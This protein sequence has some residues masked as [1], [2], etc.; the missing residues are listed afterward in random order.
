M[1][2]NRN[3]VDIH[4]NSINSIYHPLSLDQRHRII[5]LHTTQ[6]LGATAIYNR[7]IA[8]GEEVSRTSIQRCIT[9]YEREERIEALPKGGY[10][11]RTP[12]ELEDELCAFGSC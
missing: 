7:F 1:Q 4:V 3:D 10:Q 5:K 12:F 2:T 8:S 9:T 11:H 6:G